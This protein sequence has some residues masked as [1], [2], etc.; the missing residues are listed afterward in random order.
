MQAHA[1]LSFPCDFPELEPVG[2]TPLPYLDPAIPPT[3][4]RYYRVYKYTV[5]LFSR[6]QSQVSLPLL[7]Y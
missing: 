3:D 2:K 5:T 4:T 1:G 7:S 6:S